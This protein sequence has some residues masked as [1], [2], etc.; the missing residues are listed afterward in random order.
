MSRVEQCFETPA[1]HGPPLPTGIRDSHRPPPVIYSNFVG[2][3]LGLYN[4]MTSVRLADDDKRK[5][6]EVRS[7]V[8]TH[9]VRGVC[10]A[11]RATFSH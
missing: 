4:T 9:I 7:A 11:S 8:S 3:L 10:V 1:P 2:V 6:L 5:L